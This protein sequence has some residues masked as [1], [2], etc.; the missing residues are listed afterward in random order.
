MGYL[1][2]K[3]YNKQYIATFLYIYKMIN[4]LRFTAVL[5]LLLNFA[6]ASIFAQDM[7]PIVTATGDRAYCPGTSIN[8]VTDF[9]ITDPDDTTTDA[10]YIQISGGYINGQDVLSLP[11]PIPNVVT[12]WNAVSGKLTISGTGGQE[13]PYATLINAVE[14]VV[15]TSSA[16]NPAGTRTF[17]ITVGEANYLPS[18]EH[19]YRF[20]P[21]VGITWMSAKT[22]AENSNYYG[23]QGYL[24]TLLAADEAQLCG[25]Q[26]TGTGWIG[27]SDSA[28]EGVWK[29]VTGPE[30]GT[31]FWNGGVNG[32]TPNFEFWNNGEP[33]N[34]GEEDYAH[35]T[36]PGVGIP[37]SWND[38]PNAGSGGP[39]V[40]QGYIVEYGG[41]PG[42]PV[43]QISASTSITIPQ[44]SNP[45]PASRCGSGTVILQA[46]TN[47]SVVKWYAQPTGGSPLATGSS[48]TTPVLTATTTYYASGYD[49][50]CDAPRT[51]ITAT[52]NP[53]PA[54]QAGINPIICAGTTATLQASAT[55]GTVNWYATATD[56]TALGTGTS[57]TTPI[58]TSNT[59]Y[60][61]EAVSPEGCISTSRA[62]VTANVVTLPTI[63]ATTPVSIC[64]PGTVMLEA[65]ASVGATINWYSQP[66]GGTL[67][68][69]GTSITSPQVS[70]TTTFYAEAVVGSCISAARQPLQVTIT[71]QPIITATSP[72]YLCVEGTTTLT[73][74][75]T[76]GTIT[77]YDAPTG[78]NIIGTGTSLTT[79]FLTE[80]ALFYAEA[81]N[82]GCGSASRTAVEVIV[83]TLPT[84]TVIPAVTACEG[85]TALL[86]A[87]PSAGTI[88]WYDQP[89]GGSLIGTGNTIESPVISADTNFYAEAE[90]NGCISGNRETVSVVM[91][92]APEVDDET[93]YFCERSFV[94]LDAGLPGLTYEW[95]T[96][97]QS[98][99]IRV[100]APGTYTVEI[101]N[102]GGCSAVKTFTVIQRDAPVIDGIGVGTGATVM[103]LLENEDIS[104]FEYSLD[105]IIYQSSN[106]FIN[107]PAG[108][109]TAYVREINGCGSDSGRYTINLVP[110]FFTPNNDSYNDVF[111]IADIT[112]YPNVSLT[113]YDRYGKAIT[114]LNRANRVW[115]GTYNGELLPA[116]DYWY[117]LQLDFQSPEIQGHFSLMR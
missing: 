116:T 72:I 83:T 99:T 18:T 71:T 108:S 76:A 50:T 51:A 2:K 34:A 94:N 32:S 47:Y 20:I 113:I 74:T 59:T 85:E 45:V 101:I 93:V 29:W 26:A 15:Y 68:G 12:S 64:G 82:N 77:W 65:T 70:A 27:G 23:L 62:S 14:S 30:A 95:S 102:N 78:G 3:L 22:A 55:A 48:F 79:P 81:N 84:L 98:Q 109:G 5:L 105:G 115:D 80:T 41:M 40:P 43:L 92:E 16:A 38:L 61:A 104:N 88:Y 107:L 31:T 4:F 58:L 114:S 86:E 91:F 21:N 57:F 44:I 117:I 75:A 36:A 54:V 28:A 10:I 56:G 7:P 63:T 96:G 97:A 110:K 49:S 46:Q 6:P 100:T 37:G 33:N 66:T 11:T 9:N 112:E 24:A 13:L 19:Y 87:Q 39:Y 73:A 90:D 42:D 69:F 67:L 35:I 8:I 52:I 60:Y 106:T 111:T 103:I 17:S 53:F 89:S 1:P 25:E